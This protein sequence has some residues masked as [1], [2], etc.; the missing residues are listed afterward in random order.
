MVNVNELMAI[1][2]KKGEGL[3]II[4]LMVYWCQLKLK[5]Q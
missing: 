1:M 5:F 4:C 2:A 3:I